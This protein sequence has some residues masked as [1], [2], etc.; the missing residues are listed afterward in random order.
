[1]IEIAKGK[2]KKFDYK[3]IQKS[4]EKLPLD[5]FI[6]FSVKNFR[7]RRFSR[8]IFNKN[9]FKN[10][11]NT[12]FLQ[13]EKNNRLVGGLERKFKPIEENIKKKFQ[14]VII[15]NFD[16]LI[17]NKKIEIG[18]HQI[19]ITCGKNYVGYPVPEGWHRDGFDFISIINFKSSNIEG[20]ITR[21]RDSITQN[22]DSY[23]CF[24]QSEEFL[25]LNDKKFFHY[26][27][28]INVI[29]EKFIGFRDNLVLTFKHL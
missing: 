10:N 17:N 12:I 19:R 29:N 5:P 26:T 13:R 14:Q 18:L 7:S 6:V 28:P 15:E 8:L 22:S 27:D 21:I 4:F 9:K 11:S 1:M 25:F 23:S 16:F 3:A 20:G 2:L 24:L